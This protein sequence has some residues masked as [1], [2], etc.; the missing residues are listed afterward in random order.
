MCSWCGGGENWTE[1]MRPLLGGRSGLNY[2]PSPQAPLTRVSPRYR[3]LPPS[4][5]LL[6]LDQVPSQ[7]PPFVPLGS[8]PLITSPAPPWGSAPS[9]SGPG[10]DRQLLA[11]PA[12]PHP[13]APPGPGPWGRMTVTLDFEECL[14]DSPRFRWVPPGALHPYLGGHW[15]WGSISAPLGVGTW[16]WLRSAPSCVLGTP[17]EVRSA[18]PFV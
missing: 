1:P 18:P 10:R 9:L 16:G 11:V 12:S 17:G 3:L 7:A 14:K 6:F 4:N 13:P 8:A 15:G 5:L 2:S